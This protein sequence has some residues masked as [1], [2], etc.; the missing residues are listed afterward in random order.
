MHR[1]DYTNR[2]TVVVIDKDHFCLCK[3]LLIE[4]AADEE[5]A[6]ALAIP[7]EKVRIFKHKM[8]IFEDRLRGRRRA[9]RLNCRRMKRK[10]KRLPSDK[11][12]ELRKKELSSEERFKCARDLILQNYTT[13]E[14]SKVLKIS[15]RSVTRFRKRLRDAKNQMVEAGELEVPEAEEEW[16]FKYLSPELKGKINFAIKSLNYFKI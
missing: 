15:I 1:I 10:K 7:I 5:F 13:R 14:I 12:G 6:S 16:E 9:A 8:Q 3:R 11:V 2:K 4:G